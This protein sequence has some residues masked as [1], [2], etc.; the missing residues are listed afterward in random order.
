[1]NTLSF[2]KICFFLCWLFF[3]PLSGQADED[4][5]IGPGDVLSITVFDHDELQTKV[6][7]AESG[8]IDFPLIGAVEVG[9]LKTSEAAHSIA[10]L[11]ADGYIINPQ[12]HVYI[13]EFRS[14]KVVVLGPVR[15]PGVVELRGPS[16]LLEVISKA[17]GLLKEAGETITVTREVAGEQKRIVVD[18][19][20]LMESKDVESNIPILGGDAITVAQTAVCYISGEVNRPGAYPCDRDTTVL[21]M[22][23]MAGSFTGIAAKSRVRI[24]RVLDGRQQVLRNVSLDTPVFPNDVI[25]VPESLF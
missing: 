8:R 3:F 6:R 22:I 16:R 13:E 14:K 4:Y 23:S 19:K 12:I 5:Q 2:I 25:E 15:T 1:M 9:N 10:Q 18:T 20:K 7:V 11:L 24:N 17:G 21:K